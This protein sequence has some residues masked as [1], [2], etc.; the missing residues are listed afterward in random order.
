MV[1]ILLFIFYLYIYFLQPSKT[2]AVFRL[3]DLITSDLT[4]LAW[5]LLGAECPGLPGTRP[6]R[7]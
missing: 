2:K 1:F 4:P 5:N 7:P 6:G 3:Q